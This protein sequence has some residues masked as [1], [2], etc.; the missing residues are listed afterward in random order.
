MVRRTLTAQELHDRAT[1]TGC[2]YGSHREEHLGCA[3]PRAMLGV[4][5]EINPEALPPL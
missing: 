2:K 4:R 3:N 5:A 1:A